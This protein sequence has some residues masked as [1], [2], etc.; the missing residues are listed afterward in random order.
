MLHSNFSVPKILIVDDNADNLLSLEVALKPSKAVIHK[1][2]SGNEALRLVLKNDYV[3]VLL[4]VQMPEMDGYEVA[5]WMKK[6]IKTKNIPIIFVTAINTQQANITKGYNTGA[7]DYL[8]KPIDPHILLSKINVFLSL[9]RKGKDDNNLLLDKIE[10]AKTQLKEQENELELLAK[11]DTLT[12]LY[13]RLAFE[14][15]LKRIIA[16]SSRYERKSALILL[17]IDNFKWL[18]DTYGH[19]KG[20]IVLKNVADIITETIRVEDFAAR[21]GGDEFAVILTEVQNDSD[22][23]IVAEKLITAINNFDISVLDDY[24]LTISIGISCFP[25]S[26]KNFGDLVKQADIA[27]YQAKQSGRNKYKFFSLEINNSYLRYNLVR[28]ELV[29]AVKNDELFLVYQPIINLNTD[30][31]VGVEVLLRW[32]NKN[33]GIV[34]PVEFIPIAEETGEIHKIGGWV[35]KELAK[36]IKEFKNMEMND[37]FFS[38]NISPKQLLNTKFSNFFK[39]I[40]KEY[41][42][43]KDKIHIE[44]TE[45]NLGV[46]MEHSGVES[47]METLNTMNLPL[48]IDDFGIAYSSFS[49]LA[50]LPINILKIDGSFVKKMVASKKANTIIRSIIAL[51]KSLNLQTIAE[52]V[53][54]KEQKTL[55]IEN[56]CVWAQGYYFYKPLKIEELKLILS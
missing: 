36:Q 46:C 21:V 4:D 30:L 20:D 32:N 45:T 3:V 39:E 9:H 49:R 56:G 10:K 50:D 38:V 28:N 33:I 24:F 16:M 12:M 6:N 29:N 44:L 42:I 13:N 11:R 37:I 53:E 22:A 47:F 34:N 26:A 8:F 15:E 7:V 52:C 23:G 17:D 40:L 54:T 2:N 14:I 51:A 35:L 1:A 55:L 48:S 27:M 18:N 41:E 5:A 19:E 25:A 43:N 31:I